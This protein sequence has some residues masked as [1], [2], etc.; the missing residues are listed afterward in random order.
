MPLQPDADYFPVCDICQGD[1]ANDCICP[2]CPACHA[3]GDP[4]CWNK[5]E[6]LKG[7]LQL[8][9]D[10]SGW[11]HYL[12]GAAVHCGAALL[13]RKVFYRVTDAG[14]E[15]IVPT[16]DWKLVSYEANLCRPQPTVQLIVD[17]AGYRAILPHLPSMRFR[18]S[19]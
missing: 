2:E 7:A 12:E 4:R 11:R 10:P 9:R 1:P 5:P 6:H 8:R 14:D 16:D 13:L 17:V 3:H 15:E 19:A 18:W